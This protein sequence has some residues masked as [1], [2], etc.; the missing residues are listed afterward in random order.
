MLVILE[1]PTVPVAATT[2]D[3]PQLLMWGA[4]GRVLCNIKT[5]TGQ[6]KAR[7]APMAQH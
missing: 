5:F 1:A 4:G 3:P 2:W 7:T 6:E